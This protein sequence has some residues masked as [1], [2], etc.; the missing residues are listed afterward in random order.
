MA[1]LDRCEICGYNEGEGSDFANVAPGKHGKV[2]PTK[3]GFICRVCYLEIEST[4]IEFNTED[5]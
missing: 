2:Q 4:L 5:E 3:H 1:F